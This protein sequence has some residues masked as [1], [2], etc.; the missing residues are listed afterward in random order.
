VKSFDQLLLDDI[1][2][3]EGRHDDLIYQAPA[4]YRLLT[5]LLDDPGLPQRLRP[6]VLAAVAYFILPL[7]VIP[8][9]LEGPY[10]YV[11][12]IW[13][14]AFVADRVVRSADPDV[15]IRNWDGEAPLL[16]LIRDILTR[17]A[18]LLGDKKEQVLRY[19]GYKLLARPDAHRT[20]SR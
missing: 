8:E 15:L 18:E 5:R 19:I 4:L 10:G 2:S 13:L 6:L 12:D 3:Y 20:P 1:A 16:A 14:C 9:G 17:E 7:D 11:D